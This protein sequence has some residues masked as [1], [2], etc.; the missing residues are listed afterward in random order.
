MSKLVLVTGAAGFIGG[1]VTH[2]IALGED[3]DVIPLVHSISGAGTMRLGRLPVDIEQGSILDED[4]MEQ[5]LAD[6]DAVINCAHG[7]QEAT[8]DG[9]RTLLSLA[10]KQGVDTYVHMSSAVVHG[11]DASGTITEETPL[12]PDTEY[13]KR[14]A[15]AEQIVTTWDGELEP[16]VFRPCIVYGP[17]SPWVRKP[18]RHLQD[19]AV[20][21]DGGVGQVNRIYVD[22]LVDAILL[23]LDESDA[24]GEVFLAADDNPVTWSQYYQRLGRCLSDHPPIQSLSTREFVL[25]GKLRYVRDSVVPP[26]RLCKG[27]LTS[28][29][30]LQQTA[31]ELKQTPWAP[32]IYRKM[33]E[34]L[35]DDILN[36]LNTPADSDAGQSDERDQPVY[37]YPP[38]NQRKLQST[39]TRLS[40]GKLKS[41]LGWEPRVSFERG[42]EL[43]SE[44]ATYAELTGDDNDYTPQVGTGGP[45]RTNGDPE[46]IDLTA[47]EIVTGN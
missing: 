42:M 12:A 18:L 23:A 31:T 3:W 2:R 14:K 35:Q 28:P 41:T 22:N 38:E 19:G 6:C 9:T 24:A 40:T 45:Q 20:L 7:G 30:V 44:W 39:R 25:Y 29:D 33:P 21:A 43:V 10:E 46:G 16:T 32:A 13:A 36:R 11:H 37:R 17:H 5:L 1:R 47:E 4:H 34:T 15:A 27:L 8:V 26:V